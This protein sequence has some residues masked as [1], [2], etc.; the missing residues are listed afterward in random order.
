MENNTPIDNSISSS[1]NGSKPYERKVRISQVNQRKYNKEDKQEKEDDK[2]KYQNEIHYDEQN[3]QQAQMNNGQEEIQEYIHDDFKKEEQFQEDE[4]KEYKNYQNIKNNIQSREYI[5]DDNFQNGEIGEYPGISGSTQEK[6]YYKSELNNAKFIPHLE[7]NNQNGEFDDQFQYAEEGGGDE[8]MQENFDNNSKYKYKYKKIQRTEKEVEQEEGNGQNEEGEENEEFIEEEDLKEDTDNFDLQEI[9]KK[10]GRI[11]HQSTQETYDEE[12]NRVI[13]RK[14]IKEFK[15]VTGG[16]RIRNIQNEKEKIEYER[17]T[18]NYGRNNKK[19]HNTRKTHSTYKSDNRG[20]RVYLLAQLAKLKNDAEKNKLKKNQI[21]SSQSPIIIHESNGYDLYENQNSIFSNEMVEPNSFEEEMHERNYR[22]NFGTLDNHHNVINNQEYRECFFYP[23]QQTKYSANGGQM[24]EEYFGEN[25]SSNNRRDIPS[26]IGYIATYSSGSEDNEEIGRSYEQHTHKN[27]RTTHSKNKIDKN[28]YK[29]EGELIKKTEVVYELED[30]NEYIGYERKSKR[31]NLSTNAVKTQIDISKS[32][33]RDFQSPDREYGV[34]SERFRKVTMAM[35]SSLGP[36]CEDRKIT[37][38][39]RSEVGGVVDLRQD[40][41]PVNTYKIKKFQRF[42]YNLNKEV[43]PK[44]KLEGAKIIQYWWRKLKEKKIMIIKYIKIVKIQSVIRSYILRKRIT[45]TRIIYYFNEILESI[46]NNHYKKEI[47]KLFK[48]SDEDKKRRKLFNILN[49]ITDKNNKQNKIKYFYKLKYIT[50]LLKNKGSKSNIIQIKNEKEVDLE[51]KVDIEEIQDTEITEEMYMKY[52]KEKFSN[53]NKSQRINELSIDKKL[54]KPYEI[55]NKTKYEIQNTKKELIDEQTQDDINMNKKTYKEMGTQKEKENMLITNEKSIN[56]VQNKPATKE[57]KAN[58][59]IPKQLEPNQGEYFSIVDTRPNNER[60]KINDIHLKPK[61]KEPLMIKNNEKLDIFGKTKNLE[62]L[63]TKKIPEIVDK[64]TQNDIPKNEINNNSQISFL[65]KKK[66]TK[67]EYSQNDAY[68]PIISNNSLNIINRIEK[69]DESEQIGSWGNAIKKNESINFI[70]TMPKKEEKIIITN[71][72]KKA[73]SLEIIK[74]KKEFHDQ[75]MQYIPDENQIQGQEMEIKGYKP[76]T[77]ENSSQYIAKKPTICRSN[78]YSILMNKKK[79]LMNKYLINKN[80]MTIPS[81]K[82]ALKDK[83]QQYD[84]PKEFKIQEIVIGNN[85]KRG[86]TQKM[87][88]ILEEIWIKKEKSKFINNCK[89]I[90]RETMIKRELLRMAL[91]RWRFIK[92]YGGDRY[93]VIYDRNGKEIG[94]KEGL[95]NDVCI[96]ND[97]DEEI[98]NI[99]LKS[100]L[101]QNKISKQNPVYLKSNIIHKKKI[102]ADRGTGD[103]P[104]HIIESIIDK[105]TNITYNRRPKPKNKISNKN[106]FKINKIDKKLKD[107]GTYMPPKFIKIVKGNQL[108]IINKDAKSKNINKNINISRRRDLMIQMISKRIIREKYVLNDYFSKWFKTTK[109]IIEQ[110]NRYK[111]KAKK[112]LQPRISKTEKFEIIIKKPQR[113]KS[114]GPNRIVRG[115]KIE[116]KNKTIKKDVGILTNMPNM[117]KIENLKSRKVNNDEYK[118]YKKPIIVRQTNTEKTYNISEEKVKKETSSELGIPIGREVVDEINIRI[119]EIFVKFLKSRTSPKC[120]L[121]KYLSIWHRNSQY[122]PL[123]ANAKIIA[124]FCKSKLNGILVKKKWKKLF[125]KYL[126]TLR[127]YNIMKIVKKIKIRKLKIIRLI[128]MTRLITIFNKR[129]F[130]HYIMMSW[131]I[132]TITTVKKRNQI[133]MLY[134]NMLTTY[135][136]MADDIFGKNKKNNPSIQDCMFEIIDTDKYQVKELEDVPIAKIYYSK[137]NGEKKIIT[138]IKYIEKEI[139]DEKKLGFYKEMTKKYYS[140]NRYNTYKTETETKTTKKEV[141]SE[142]RGIT[143]KGV[144]SNNNSINKES[145][146]K[147]N[148]NSPESKFL[149]RSNYNGKVEK[150]EKEGFAKYTYKGHQRTDNNSNNSSNKGSVAVFKRRNNTYKNKNTTEKIESS[151]NSNINNRYSNIK[152]EEKEKGNKNIKSYT[153]KSKYIKN[154]FYNTVGDDKQKTEEKIKEE[155]KNYY[156][157]RYAINTIGGKDNE[158]YKIKYDINDNK[159]ANKIEYNASSSYSGHFYNANRF[160]NNEEKK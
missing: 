8:N 146:G 138:N 77:K 17:Y 16:I 2:I 108:L 129:K 10:P 101:L 126:F 26:P 90:S 4:N 6:K 39:M 60:E 48:Y 30:P 135:V 65:Y 148:S 78:Q 84:I 76:Q 22:N 57:D 82:K 24:Q 132:Y 99:K 66:E 133:K 62:D 125:K 91:L 102:T 106:Y 47:L 147:A 50:D 95:V 5:E 9:K 130:L 142:T 67:D 27:V 56:F 150:I 123:I 136:S 18:S 143:Y 157:N 122:M 75:E 68:K 71:N 70:S 54:K 23:S 113:E 121:R 29:K 3:S 7:I 93:G 107:Q 11:L 37:R 112:I 87:I 119:T 154:S 160:N 103:E 151:F 134:E 32:D 15:Q 28:I 127:Q 45:T 86:F 61:E 120:I 88:E 13:T 114:A 85:I 110:E 131:L 96:Q 51:K 98:K 53:N 83:G 144:Y 94:K 25:H 80:N 155:G 141:K 19:I 52:I 156:K 97:L 73:I 153:Y 149:K 55:D 40:L 104:N 152:D 58:A 139:E 36:T 117:F 74:N 69:C 81:K 128:R 89:E 145:K 105:A 111:Y 21:Y 63:G 159:N 31:H 1:K 59:S 35:I 79:E 124:T 137:K 116:F 140:P 92:G 38:K 41:N 42:G 100:K 158:K 34:G 49:L 44:T 14:T 33:K 115:A 43:N 20:D 12:G 72:I 64:G 118:S 46:F 109:R